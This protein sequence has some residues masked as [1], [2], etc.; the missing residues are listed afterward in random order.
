MKQNEILQSGLRWTQEKY[1]YMKII[2]LPIKQYSRLTLKY[3]KRSIQTS[4]FRDTCI[5]S[6]KVC[7]QGQ[8][9]FILASNLTRAPTETGNN[10]HMTLPV[11]P[12]RQVTTIT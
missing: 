8:I 11:H 9:L 5:E 4:L 1:R 6:L 3:C 12:Y 2:T 7:L 10:H